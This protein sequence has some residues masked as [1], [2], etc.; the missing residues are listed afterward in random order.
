MPGAHRRG[1]AHDADRAGRG[2]DVRAP[3]RATV[4]AFLGAL[5]PVRGGDLAA[6]DTAT[7]GL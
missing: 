6:E 4:D 3:E 1:A 2:R 5:D 7:V